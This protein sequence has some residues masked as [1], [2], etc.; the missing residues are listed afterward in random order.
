MR[1]AQPRSWRALSV[2]IVTNPFMNML[3]IHGMQL[4]AIYLL[5]CARERHTSVMMAVM[6]MHALA[7]LAYIMYAE[8]GLQLKAC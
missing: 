7:K 8:A 6:H 1:V 2:N 4:H 5:F 3:F